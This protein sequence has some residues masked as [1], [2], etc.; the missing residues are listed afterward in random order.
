MVASQAGLPIVLVGIGFTRAWRAR[1][2]DRFAVP[3]PFSTLVGVMS[4]PIMIPK[5]L[6]R[7][8][9]QHYQ[10]LVEERLLELTNEAESWAER[11][12]I[13][14]RNAQPPEL[15]TATAGIRKSA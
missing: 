12:R 14:G 4:E 1:S 13:E 11:L 7:P 10:R 9:M 3:L 2:W 6:D 15:R 8:G 5:D